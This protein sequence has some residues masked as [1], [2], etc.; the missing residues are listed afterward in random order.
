M[1]AD[2]RIDGSSV[3]ARVGEICRRPLELAIQSPGGRKERIA[4]SLDVESTTGHPPEVPI[5]SI[6][7]LIRL[8]AI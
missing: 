6:D 7:L 3:V 1:S 4:P 8:V 5:V 2:E